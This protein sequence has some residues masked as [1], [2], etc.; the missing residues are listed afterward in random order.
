MTGPLAGLRVVELAG[1][2]SAPHAATLLAGLG[3]HVVRVAR[4]APTPEDELED[5]LGKVDRG[6]R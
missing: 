2:G 1:L 5:P 6:C 3:A 4:T